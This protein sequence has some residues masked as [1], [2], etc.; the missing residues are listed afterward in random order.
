M[1]TPDGW[2]VE[3][4][5]FGADT[6]FRVTCD[7]DGSPGEGVVVGLERLVE[8][9]GESFELLDAALAGEGVAVTG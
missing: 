9:L 1:T 8:L 6:R 3:L 7:G 5:R 2:R 4:V